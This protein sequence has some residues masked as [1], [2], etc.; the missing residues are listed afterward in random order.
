MKQA[1]RF[2]HEGPLLIMSAAIVAAV[3]V[4]AWQWISTHDISDATIK[5]MSRLLLGPEQFL[6]YFCFCWAMLILWTRWWEMG[7]QRRPFQVEL[8]PPEED[9]RLLPE[10]ARLWQRRI[11]RQSLS[12][13]QPTLLGKLIDL[14]LLRFAS[15][16]SPAEVATAIRESSDLA[17]NRLVTSLSLV[18]YLAWAIPALGFIGT[19]RGMGMALAAAPSLGSNEAVQQFLDQTTRSLGFTFDCTL[20]ALSL[21][22]VLMFFIHLQQRSEEQLVLDAQQFCL[23]RLLVKLV[24]IDSILPAA[25]EKLVGVPVKDVPPAAPPL[26]GN[27]SLGRE[28]VTRDFGHGLGGLS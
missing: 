3:G 10:D 23:E 19:A 14:A 5:R 8:L 25:P 15:C 13:G 21:S 27:T 22:V 12:G 11:Q 1:F 9:Y 24:N 16:R 6:C 26:P 28:R 2:A 17:Q 18:Q 7:R 4:P 20:V